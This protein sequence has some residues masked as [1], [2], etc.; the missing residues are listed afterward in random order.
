MLEARIEALSVSQA[1]DAVKNLRL[2]LGGPGSDEMESKASTALQCARLGDSGNPFAQADGAAS[3]IDWNRWYKAALVLALARGFEAEVADAIQ[4]AELSGSK[5]ISI[6]ALG[7]FSVL[8]VLLKYR[9][10]TVEL[11][12]EKFKATWRDNDVGIL[13]QLLGAM[14]G[15]PIPH[16]QDS[17]SQ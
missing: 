4:D 7:I 14:T 13:G 9:P 10:T 15:V 11:S 17:D 2:A 8:L 1:A 6:G 16:R 5:D 3:K 12:K